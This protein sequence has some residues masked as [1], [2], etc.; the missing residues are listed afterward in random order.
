MTS[1][2]HRHTDQI[3]AADTERQLVPEHKSDVVVADHVEVERR[4]T[5]ERSD[6]DHDEGE[7]I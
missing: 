2:V 3:A 1:T 7:G 4:N 5:V 6:A